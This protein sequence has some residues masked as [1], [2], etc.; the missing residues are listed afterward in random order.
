MRSG[1]VLG[2]SRLFVFC[3]MILTAVD[4]KLCLDSF[5]AAFR[6]YDSPLLGVLRN[7]GGG[8]ITANSSCLL[9]G[10][11]AWSL[12]SFMVFQWLLLVAFGP[13]DGLAMMSWTLYTCVFP[14]LSPPNS[15]GETK[16][17]KLKNL[18]PQDYASY[19]CQ[20]SVRNVCSIPDK[21]I[22]FQLTNTTGNVKAC[23]AAI[24]SPGLQQWEDHLEFTC[25]AAR[26]VNP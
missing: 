22:T 10:R 20:V 1:P 9:W 8:A 12:H 13:G 7:P 26:V 3:K 14:S 11:R 23:W 2:R 24:A 16:V 6:L 21:S 19:T 15:Q 18:R 4:K 17:L 25:V 5:S